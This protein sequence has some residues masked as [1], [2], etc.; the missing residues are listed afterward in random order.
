MIDF[1]CKHSFFDFVNALPL[2][3]PA[4]LLF[5]PALLPLLP[6]LPLL[7]SALLPLLPALLRLLPACLNLTRVRSRKDGEHQRAQALAM[8]KPVCLALEISLNDLLPHETYPATR[9]VEDFL[10][11]CKARNELCG[12]VLDGYTWQDPPA[13]YKARP[14]RVPNLLF[15]CSLCSRSGH[16]RD[17]IWLV[18]GAGLPYCWSGPAQLRHKMLFWQGCKTGACNN[19]GFHVSIITGAR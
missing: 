13:F 3:L 4:L 16:A 7:L 9:T 8:L 2:L 12:K 15:L 6:A 1:I 17:K 18:G 14:C 10:K 5:L 11:V 19:S